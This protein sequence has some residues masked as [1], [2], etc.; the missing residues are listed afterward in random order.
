MYNSEDIESWKN[1]LIMGKLDD[2][3]LSMLVKIVGQKPPNIQNF[4][5]RN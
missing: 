5:L 1:L 2:E 4:F 3:K